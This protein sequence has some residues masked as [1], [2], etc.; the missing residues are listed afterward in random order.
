MKEV[1]KK[2]LPEISGGEFQDGGGCIPMPGLPGPDGPR[3]PTNPGGPVPLEDGVY[4][5]PSA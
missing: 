1:P 2:D 5:D 4:T 3:Y